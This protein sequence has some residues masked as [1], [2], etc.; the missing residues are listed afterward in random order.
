MRGCLPVS[1]GED[2]VLCM[3][4]GR[5]EDHT[6]TRDLRTEAHLIVVANVRFKLF[7]IS[8]LSE[9]KKGK[10]RG[11]MS[12]KESG[13]SLKFRKLFLS[14]TAS[15]YFISMLIL[16]HFFFRVGAPKPPSMFSPFG[17]IHFG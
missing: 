5:S 17:G 3:R 16:S 15:E 14:H 11:Q 10:R 8:E 1:S 13:E 2:A 6:K 7:N 12:F 9:R 4:K